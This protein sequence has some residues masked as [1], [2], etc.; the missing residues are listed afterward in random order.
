MTRRLPEGPRLSEEW[1]R[2][3]EQGE[4]PGFAGR[5]AEEM[6]RNQ[7]RKRKITPY[8]RRRRYRRI[9]LTVSPELIEDLRRI[10]REYGYV[11]E[12]GKGIISSRVVERLLRLAVEAYDA[13][14]IEQYEEA[15]LV[16]QQAFRWKSAADEG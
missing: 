12:E 10:C 3:V 13:G 1:R 9:G 15:V 5:T 8:E 7:T 11:D 4:A 2:L 6:Q 14:M 16:R